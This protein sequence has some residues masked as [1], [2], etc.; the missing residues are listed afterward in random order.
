MLSSTSSS[1]SS[2]KPKSFSFSSSSSIRVDTRWY[3]TKMY[4]FVTAI[5]SPSLFIAHWRIVSSSFFLP[6]SSS[7]SSH[8][9]FGLIASL[10]IFLFFQC[11]IASVRISNDFL[12]T[13]RTTNAFF[14]SFFA[15]APSRQDNPIRRPF[16]VLDAVDP[17]SAPRRPPPPGSLDVG[18]RILVIDAVSLI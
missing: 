8:N 10:V 17:S 5:A 3:V 1:S 13:P 4:P 2:N 14:P 11:P 9:A 16:V 18:S 7:S 12:S 6:S 15:R